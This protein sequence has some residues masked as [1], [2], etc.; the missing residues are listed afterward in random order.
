M[1]H[2][3]RHAA[4]ERPVLARSATRRAGVRGEGGVRRMIGAACIC[5]RA[6][7]VCGV[8]VRCAC[9]V[10]VYGVRVR[11]EWQGRGVGPRVVSWRSGRAAPPRLPP[12]AR[13]AAAQG[14]P[15]DRAVRP[16]PRTQTSAAAAGRT[17]SVVGADVHRAYRGQRRRV[18]P[19]SVRQVPEHSCSPSSASM[20]YGWS[21]PPKL[22]RQPRASGWASGATGGPVAVVSESVI[23]RAAEQRA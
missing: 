13:D 5:A 4:S 18:E 8:R 12:C 3:A 9:T 10:C 15:A 1:T 7:R 2:S 17:H 22:R 14:V 20:G 19:A 6:V 21:L 11:C 16:A 23:D